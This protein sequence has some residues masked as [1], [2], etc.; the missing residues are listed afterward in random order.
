MSAQTKDRL[1]EIALDLF[2]EGGYEGTTTREICKR[3]GVNVAALNYHWGSKESLWHAACEWAGQSL[4]QTVQPA[5]DLSRNPAEIVEEVVGACFDALVVDP[6]PIR[7]ITWAS[8]Q[9]HSIDFGAAA[10]RFQP[11]VR[12]GMSFI[13]GWVEAGLI[14]DIDHE[15]VLALWWGQMLVAFIDEPGHR[16]FFGVD[17]SDPAHASRIRAGLVASALH[18]LGLATPVKRRSR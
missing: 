1:F 18:A 15:V 4:V 8:M 17:Y 14:A 7:I 13:E 11:F 2:A 6:R 9:A 3:A 5:L 12:L 10:E 16:V